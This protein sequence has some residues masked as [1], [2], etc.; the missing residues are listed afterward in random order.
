MDTKEWPLQTQEKMPGIPTQMMDL[1][2][3]FVDVFPDD[4]P[5]GLPPDRG[6]EHTIP[7]EPVAK[8]I[9]RPMYRL[10]PLEQEEAKKQITEYLAK[11]WIAPSSSPYGQPIFLCQRKG[12]VCGCVSIIERLTNKPSKTDMPCHVSMIC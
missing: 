3:A 10:R 6:P 2:D 1:L 4:L 5:N 9:F 8:S 11:G 12:G 7:L